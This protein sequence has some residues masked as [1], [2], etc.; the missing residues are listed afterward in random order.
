[1]WQDYEKHGDSAAYKGIFV[2]WFEH[3]PENPEK[4]I[5]PPNT[6]WDADELELKA[7]FNLED[8][9]LWWRRRILVEKCDNNKN[10]FDTHY[11]SDVESC[12]LAGALKVF[13]PET[14]KLQQRFVKE[15]NRIGT[16]ESDGK[17]VK[18]TDDAAGWWKIYQL[19]QVNHSYSLGVDSS[20][21]SGHDPSVIIIIDNETGEQTAKFS[22]FLDAESLSDEM[23]KAAQLYNKGFINPEINEATGLAALTLLKQKYFNIYKRQEFD[24]AN[25]TYTSKLGFYTSSVTKNFILANLNI[26]LKEGRIKVRDQQTF[27]ELT[28]FIHVVDKKPDGRL[29]VTAKKQAEVGCFDDEVI[30]LALALEMQRARPQEDITEHRV[31]SNRQEKGIEYVEIDNFLL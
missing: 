22:G 17:K 6:K 9:H 25:K 13:K 30:A 1:V 16:L 3:Y 18:F 10:Y 5:P 20:T 19:P 29:V 4:F 21:G 2:P 24:S 26:A 12:W 14:L 15:P 7:R 23:F 28:T 8:Y 31:V 27:D 11:P